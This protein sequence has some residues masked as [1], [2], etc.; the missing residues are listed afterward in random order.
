[1]YSY[2]FLVLIFFCHVLPMFGTE[3]LLFVGTGLGSVE[4][5]AGPR[6]SPSEQPATVFNGPLS[7]SKIARL[8]LVVQLG[9][10]WLSGFMGGELW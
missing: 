4:E 1:M 2:V 5:P 8:V 3:G 7:R 6:T 10:A 9:I